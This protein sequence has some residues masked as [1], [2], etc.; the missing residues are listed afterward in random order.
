MLFI[1]LGNKKCLSAFTESSV[2]M[3]ER[4]E[5]DHNELKTMEGLEQF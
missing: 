5:P 3:L 4:Q 1:R 2:S